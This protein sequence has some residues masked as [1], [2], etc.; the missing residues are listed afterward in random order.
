MKVPSA[1]PLHVSDDTLAEVNALLDWRAST[2]LPDGRVVGKPS[3]NKRPILNDI[4]DRRIKL[5][6]DGMRLNGKTVLEIGCF[7]G[8]HTLGM[9]ELGAQVTGVDIRPVNVAK[10]L[11]RLSLYGHSTPVFLA[12]CED[13]DPAFGHFDIVFHFG[14]LYH[15]TEPVEHL[16]KMAQRGDVLYLDT[17][18]AAPQD[19]TSHDV[20]DAERYAYRRVTEGGWR[21]PFSGPES[22]AKH[23][24][25]TA[26]RAALTRAG[27]TQIK[28][29]RF[30]A[31]RNGP[32]V[33]MIASTRSG[34]DAF[35]S[36]DDPEGL[37]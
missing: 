12:D 8:I 10:T 11:M 4:P 19:A 36:I 18:V 13:I 22:Y 1:I 34:L 20:I 3:A 6:N 33:L 15:L 5:L 14:V 25:L 26:L 23:L 24:T 21:D 29:L 16:A 37:V 32:R 35:T 27:Y 7:E 30:R 31:E 9:L 17:H 28:L 2:A